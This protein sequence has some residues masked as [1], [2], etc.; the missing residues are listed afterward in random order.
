MEINKRIVGNLDYYLSLPSP[1]YA[2][3]LCGEWGVGK[4]YFIDKYIEKKNGRD[5][6]L[7]KISL[8]GLK[9]TSEIN[10]NI[11]QKLHPVLGSKG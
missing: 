11:F 9:N 10:S 8:F 6:R 2:F 3:L 4:T 5:L 7:I 1:E